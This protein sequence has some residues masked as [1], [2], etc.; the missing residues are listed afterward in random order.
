VNSNS[1]LYVVYISNKSNRIEFMIQLL[2]Y[3]QNEIS[4]K[5]I[6]QRSWHLRSDMWFRMIESTVY[7]MGIWIRGPGSGPGSIDPGAIKVKVS[8][9]EDHLCKVIVSVL[10]KMSRRI[11]GENIFS[12]CS[13]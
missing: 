3:L 10:E 8:H 1:I 13:N 9:T 11:S 12:N 4:F 6:C 7:T 2:E 5:L